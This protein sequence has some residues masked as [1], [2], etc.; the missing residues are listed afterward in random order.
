MRRILLSFAL[1]GSWA[2]TPAAP[3]QASTP[4][5]IGAHI[6]GNMMNGP[7][8]LVRVGGQLLIPL[9][10]RVDAYPAVS[11]FLD[12]GEWQVSFALRYRP[13]AAPGSPLYLGAGWTGINFGP[14]RESY[15][16]WLTGV[17][18]PVGR[19]RP[20]VEMQFLGPI[21]SMPG[22]V[23]VQAYAGITWAAR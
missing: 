5:R 17:E 10:T 23:L 19:L 21:V 15:D 14:Q 16:L 8:D 18:V 9:G 12:G 1:L 6:A 20:Y 13:F 7:F 11:R 4:L 2:V 3:Q 22:G